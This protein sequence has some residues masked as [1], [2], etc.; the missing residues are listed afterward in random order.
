MTSLFL[1]AS[2]CMS[3]E[4]CFAL[5]EAY[6]S[7]DDGKHL[8]PFSNGQLLAASEQDP[9]LYGMMRSFNQIFCSQRITIE[10]AFGQLVRK[11]GILWGPIIFNSIDRVP[12][13][14]TACAHLHNL[15]VDSFL[16][17]KFGRDMD[18][19]D[20]HSDNP[21]PTPKLPSVD[22]MYYRDYT[23][24]NEGLRSGNFEYAARGLDDHDDEM[25]AFM[26][27]NGY[28]G[29]IPKVDNTYSSLNMALS[30]NKTNKSKLRRHEMMCRIKEQ[31]F[32]IV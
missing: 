21:Y 24:R 3:D 2:Q 30:K 25:L 15:S 8:T 27:R 6:A 28:E 1:V 4:Y 10:R 16:V 26:I 17:G 20:A 13:I 19:A 29:E 14:L 7:I 31:G 12:L 22:P 23:R 11:F 32:E 5:D 18:A 9:I